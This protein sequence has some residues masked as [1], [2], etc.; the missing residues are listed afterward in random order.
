[1]DPP[2]GHNS[3]PNRPRR[4]TI[5]RASTPCRFRSHIN[6]ETSLL[7]SRTSYIHRITNQPKH[8]PT[9]T[10]TSCLA[11]AIPLAH[12]PAPA[13]LRA[14]PPRLLSL[15][16]LVLRARRLL[17]SST[18]RLLLLSRRVLV[19]LARWL[20]LLRKLCI[21]P[22]YSSKLHVSPLP[23]GY[24]SLGH[25]KRE[26][27]ELGAA[28]CLLYQIVLTLFV[29]FYIVVSLSVPPSATLSAASLAAAHRSL[30]PSKSSPR[31]PPSR[32]STATT[33]AP[34]PRRLS[35]SAWTT[36]RATCRFATGTLSSSRPARLLP[37]STKSGGSC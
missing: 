16:S 15:S 19:C 28:F 34:A 4:I 7:S 9:T 13:P 1:M 5:S 30:L 21:P 8:K 23:L 24:G 18:L 20:A 27:Q 31:L 2:I 17:L 37:A 36:T 35:P 25:C 3:P 14:L 6:L 12:R 26:I 22:L 11:L 10:P 33:T 32:T 29:C